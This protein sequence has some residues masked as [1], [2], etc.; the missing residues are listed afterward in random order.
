MLIAVGFSGSST[1]RSPIP[2]SALPLHTHGPIMRTPVPLATARADG[3][4]SVLA[5]SSYSP[6]ATPRPARRG[7]EDRLAQL[8]SL[9]RDRG[10]ALVP[11]DHHDASLRRW[12]ARQRAL[13]RQGALAASHIEELD[14]VGFVWDILQAQWEARFEELERFFEEHGHTNVPS[15]WAA[16][17]SLAAWVS[18]RG[19]HSACLL[20]PMCMRSMHGC[21]PRDSHSAC[22]LRPMCTCVPCMHKLRY[23]HCVCAAG[24]Q[25]HHLSHACAFSSC[26]SCACATGVHPEACAPRGIAE[27]GAACSPRQPGRK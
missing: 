27:S 2:W 17:P 25:A 9:V 22:L 26:A 8:R 5:V 19:S 3:N 16:D 23:V 14:A 13:R 24:E 21:R 4:A 18:P 10:S 6:L 12:S 11:A 1:L 15:S 7:L 20:R